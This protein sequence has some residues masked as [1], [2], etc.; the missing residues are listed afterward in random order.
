MLNFDEA[1]I[2]KLKKQ[3][4]SAFN[5]FYLKTV[6]MF[7]RYIKGNYY[8][9]DEDCHDVISTFY[10]KQREAFKNIDPDQWF[11]AYIWTIFKNTLKDYFKKRTDVP[12]TIIDNPE[13]WIYFDEQL[14]D[15]NSD[16]NEL[17]EQDFKFEQIQEALWKLDAISRDIIH[18]KFIEEKSNQEIADLLQLSNTNIRQKLSRALK[19]LK[20]LLNTV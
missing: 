12:F 11:S 15:E 20:T 10:V 7:F 9:K 2:K 8:V 14:E 13:E 5:E 17:F 1:F 6:D 18:M 16:L 4:H 3:D 19:Q